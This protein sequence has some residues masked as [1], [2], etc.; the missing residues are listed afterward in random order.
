MSS[1]DT[2]AVRLDNIFLYMV[3]RAGKVRRA[4]YEIQA[5]ITVEISVMEAENALVDEKLFS[6]WIVANVDEKSHI[7]CDGIE[8]VIISNLGLTEGM[9]RA[10]FLRSL[11]GAE[12]REGFS[13]YLGQLGEDL[14]EMRATLV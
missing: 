9:K 5:S 14:A 10:R 7:I 6:R 3:R 11:I 12:R 1:E 4:Y 8:K 2:V 13:K